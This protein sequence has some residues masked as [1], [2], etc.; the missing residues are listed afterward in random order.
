[1]LTENGGASE[2]IKFTVPGSI[3]RIMDMSCQD[4]AVPGRCSALAL[5]L[6]LFAAWQ[7]PAFGVNYGPPV[8]KAEWQ[9]ERS[10]LLCRLSQAVPFFGAAEFRQ[11]A[12]E[13][14]LFELSSS[15]PIAE[16]TAELR[17][18]VPPWRHENGPGLLGVVPVFASREPVLLD[19][20]LSE[21]LL[22]ALYHGYMPVLAGLPWQAGAGS[23]DVSLSAVN[24]QQAYHDYRECISALIPARFQDLERSRIQFAVS[25]WQ[26]GEADQ[27]RLDL[28]VR[29]VLADRFITGVYVDGYA[30]QL[31]RRSVNRELSKRRAEAVTRYLVARGVP[32][33]K[34]T[35]RHHGEALPVSKGTDAKSLA[36]NRRVTVRLERY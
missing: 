34:I 14:S 22:S 15:H 2:R 31:G 36:E 9:L 3:Q 7:S 21:Q 23:V 24:F 29:Y 16:G 18:D 10:P 12:G 8:D 11:P 13:A 19:A 30:D 33:D 6:L 28:V 35:T 1:M 27:A 32:E 17:V 25:Q 26:I 4:S 20:A 5:V